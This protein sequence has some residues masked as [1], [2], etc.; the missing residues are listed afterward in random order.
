MFL[1]QRNLT[2]GA[3]LDLS[4]G[5]FY[6]GSQS[7][8]CV[9]PCSERYP[10]HASFWDRLAAS[11][12]PFR[13]PLL[14]GLLLELC[15]FRHRIRLLWK[16]GGTRLLEIGSVYQEQG[17]PSCLVLNRQTHLRTQGI[18]RLLSECPWLT[19]EDCHLF[20]TGWNA[21][22]ESCECSG[23]ERSSVDRRCPLFPLSQGEA[24]QFY[25]APS[26]SAIDQT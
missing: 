7:G 17:H 5:V 22:L 3:C 13:H 10:R 4:K 20:L 8:D 21:A 6:H 2:K 19:G 15:S 14:H 12:F 18:Q 26:S 11:K 23:T 25:A 24:R 16:R 9:R 1:K